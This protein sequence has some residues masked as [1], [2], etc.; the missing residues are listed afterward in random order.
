MRPGKHVLNGQ[1]RKERTMFENHWTTD[2]RADRAPNLAPRSFDI[3]REAPPSP[4]DDDN[5]SVFA[6][7]VVLAAP[8]LLA[9]A[10]AVETVAPG[11]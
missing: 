7:A 8:V 9:V 1:P 2:V 11:I 6:L 4:A 5:R 3:L 10:T